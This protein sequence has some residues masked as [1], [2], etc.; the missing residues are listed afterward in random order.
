MK[1]GHAKVTIIPLT[2]VI[3]FVERSAAVIVP[4]KLLAPDNAKKFWTLKSPP[5]TA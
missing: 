2:T 1:L 5:V 4:V 3:V